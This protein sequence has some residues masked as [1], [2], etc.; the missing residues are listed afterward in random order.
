MRKPLSLYKENK[1]RFKMY[2]MYQMKQLT[3]GKSN[4]FKNSV[5]NI[6]RQ[7][8]CLKNIKYSNRVEFF[9]KGRN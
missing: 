5:L 1:W 6:K 7:I 4:L 8:N 2:G 9:Q 3:V